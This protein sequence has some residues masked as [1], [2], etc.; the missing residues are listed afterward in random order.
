[1]MTLKQL[2]CFAFAITSLI[3]IGDK[4][5]TIHADQ[6]VAPQTLAGK[7]EA[8]IQIGSVNVVVI[9]HVTVNPDHSYSAHMDVPSAGRKNVLVNEFRQE[10]NEVSLSIKDLIDFKGTLNPAGDTFSGKWKQAGQP[11]LAT[12]RKSNRQDAPPVP[13][14]QDPKR[15]FPYREEEVVVQSRAGTKVAGTLTLPPS[16]NAGD[17]KYPAVLLIAGSGPQNRDEMVAGH[18]PFLVISDFLTR[19]GVAVLRFDKR[20]IGKSTGHFDEADTSDFADDAEACFEY[21]RN[22]AEVDS[23]RIG[24]IGHSEGGTVASI[25]AS[26]NSRVAFVV[27]LAA[28]GLPGEQLVYSQSAAILRAEGA[29]EDQIADNRRLQEQLISVLKS[30]TNPVVAERQLREIFLAKYN[31][32]S[33]A[34]SKALGN[35]TSLIDRE[36]KRLLSRASRFGIAYDPV[37]TL[38]NVSCPVLAIAGEK[39]V[40]VVASENLP[41]IDAA[42]KSTGNVRSKIQSLSQLNH[43]FQT[44]KTGSMA[45]YDKIEE[46]VAPSAMTIIGDWVEEQIN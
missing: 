33:S 38:K 17:V 11:F 28:P 9:L 14:P 5:S 26:R 31:S 40:V 15:P 36:I 35:V 10:G 32:L 45:E 8:P 37:T 3:V 13:R 6:P 20:G 39:D 12:F 30:E 4:Q 21:L 23:K 25:V 22:R 41:R 18:R 46:T 24:L 19:K 27:L 43:L 44:C 16:A 34:E 2:Y 1:M 7:W 29:G 42:L